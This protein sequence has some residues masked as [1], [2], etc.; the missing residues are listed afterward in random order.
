M[1]KILIGTN[2]KNPTVVG[3][4]DLTATNE[5]KATQ[6]PIPSG[7]RILCALPEVDKEYDSGIIKADETLRYEG[8]LATVLFVVAMGPDCYADKERFP[9]GP[10]CKVG[11]FVLVR[12]NAGTRLKIHGTEMRV[13]N[14]DTVEGTVL[15]PRGI[16]RA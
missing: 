5:E 9:S 12:P 4:I 16:S 7:F 15:D 14:D 6:L 1:S 2:A 10:W 3:S 8:L 13:I 11:D